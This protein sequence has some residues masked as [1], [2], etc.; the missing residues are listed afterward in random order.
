MD[1][2]LKFRLDDFGQRKEIEKNGLYVIQ[3]GVK[4][5]GKTNRGENG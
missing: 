1:F 3:L 4:L 5:N 2:V